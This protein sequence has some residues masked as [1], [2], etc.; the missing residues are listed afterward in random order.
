MSTNFPP[1]GAPLKVA[2]LLLS[3]EEASALLLVTSLLRLTESHVL[4]LQPPTPKLFALLARDLVSTLLT[5]SLLSVLPTR[6]KPITLETSI[7]MSA[8][9]LKTRPGVDSLPLQTANLLLCPQALTFWSILIP[10][11]SSTWCSSMAALSSSP[12]T[13]TLITSEPL[14]LK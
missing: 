4:F 9:G 10:L 13:V 11:L 1:D 7:A 8:S 2:P 12:L 5:H 14:M 6:A 3:L